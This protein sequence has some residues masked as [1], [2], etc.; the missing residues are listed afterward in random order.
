MNLK[1]KKVWSVEQ[2]LSLPKE[3]DAVK[4]GEWLMINASPWAYG[5]VWL[6]FKDRSVYNHSNLWDFQSRTEGEEMSRK[7]TNREYIKRYFPH[8]VSKKILGYADKD[9]LGCRDW[10][11]LVCNRVCNRER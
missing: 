9:F 8:K 1:L 7:M 4:F 11:L 10:R 3:S 2:K 5:D 6:V